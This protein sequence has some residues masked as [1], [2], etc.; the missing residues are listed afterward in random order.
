MTPRT[1]TFLKVIFFLKYRYMED[2]NQG[3]M[4]RWQGD[5][6]PPTFLPGKTIYGENN[7]SN[8]NHVLSKEN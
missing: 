7:D 6:L 4:Y 1:T 8:C 3:R 2:L 5:Q